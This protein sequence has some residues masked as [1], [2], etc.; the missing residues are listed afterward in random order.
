ML[1]D[2]RYKGAMKRKCDEC[3]AQR[4]ARARAVEALF[5]IYV[6]RVEHTDLSAALMIEIVDILTAHGKI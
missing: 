6:A 4:A 5:R 1:S 3:A 2:Q